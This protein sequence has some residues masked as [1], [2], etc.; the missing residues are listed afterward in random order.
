MEKRL[1]NLTEHDITVLPEGRVGVTAHILGARI[2]RTRRVT[3]P[4][5]GVVARVHAVH[6][7]VARVTIDGG[8]I[9]IV[10]TRFGEIVGLPAP[11][12]GVL[13][14]AST[15]VAQAAARAGRR[16]VVAPDTGPDSVIRGPDGR[17]VA[18]QRF[19]TFWADDEEEAKNV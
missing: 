2:R 17:P 15:L 1:I 14:I 16:D 11:E 3:I 19:Q 10:S 18:V 6:E 7:E 9:S 4:P 8:D 12:P 13:Y 5:S